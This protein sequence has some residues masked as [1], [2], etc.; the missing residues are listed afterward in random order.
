[1]KSN[2]TDLT[3]E[4]R[5]SDLSQVKGNA[6]IVQSLEKFLSDPAKC[7]HTFLFSG[8][9][10]CGKT[11]FARIIAKGLGCSGADYQEINAADFRGIDMVREIIKS[12][13]YRPFESSCRVYV[14]DETHKMT[15]DAQNA[16]LKIAEEPPKH[17]YFIFCTTEFQKIISALRG[18]CHQYQV[19]PLEE[20]QLTSLIKKI[21]KEKQETIEDEVMKQII[22]DSLGHPR[23]A[24]K[25]LEQVLSVS[26]DNR[27]EI[28]KK[29]QVEQGEV[30]ELFRALINN[31]KWPEVAVI[32]SRLKEVEAETIRRVIL[33]CCSTTLLN[34][35]AG[36]NKAAFIMECFWQNTYD[37]GFVGI[38][39][40]SYQ[41]TSN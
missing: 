4:Y 7:P 31:K 32:L 39:Y 16:F 28:A 34:N 29:S 19:K 26:P 5:P 13:Q 15:S 25:I 17:V 11:T 27:L 35:P 38:V 20:R 41:V 10:G 14:I 36:N 30:I 6:Q 18:R 3:A 21:L 22:T 33:G 12:A 40:A 9:T 24:L 2:N 23:N 1:M 37:T 8:P